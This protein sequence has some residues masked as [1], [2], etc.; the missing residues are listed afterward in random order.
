MY[1]MMN[2]INNTVYLKVAKGRD[3]KCSHDNK[4]NYVR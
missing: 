2:I 3:I 1:S 4:G